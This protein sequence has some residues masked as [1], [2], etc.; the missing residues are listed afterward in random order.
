MAQAR[1]NGGG[2]PDPWSTANNTFNNT[3]WKKDLATFR[4][5][6]DTPP[7]DRGESPSILNYR[8]CVGDDYHQNH[9]RP[10]QNRNN[11]GMFQPNRY[12]SIAEDLDG[13]SNTIMFGESVAGGAPDDVLGGIALN[14]EAW[15]PAACL[16]RLCTVDSRKITA[17]VQAVLRPAGGRAWDGRQYF[18]SFATMMAPNGPSCHWGGVDGTENM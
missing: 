15:N 7:D 10:D 4:C 17:P 9:F 2:L 1:P 16:A 13:T 5:P 6:S 3:Y 18:G 8:G 14:M 12:L 11:R